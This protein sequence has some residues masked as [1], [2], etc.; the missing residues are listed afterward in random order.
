[1]LTVQ[2]SGIGSLIRESEQLDETVLAERQAKVLD[3]L[4]HLRIGWP[5]DRWSFDVLWN[6]V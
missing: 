1:V 2:F 6:N 3:C 5:V 4:H